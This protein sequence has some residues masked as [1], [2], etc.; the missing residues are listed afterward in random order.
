MKPLQSRSADSHVREVTHAGECAPVRPAGSSVQTDQF[1]QRDAW[2]HIEGP[3]HANLRTWLSA[4]R[5]LCLAALALA[6]GARAQAQSQPLASVRYATNFSSVTYFEPPHE[7]QVKMRLSGA[8]A[9]PLPNA[10]YDL[11]KMKVEQFNTEGK[12]AA[13]VKA[14]QCTYA[15]LDHVASSPGHL[16]IM[17]G[18]GKLQTEGD[19][20]LLKESEQSLVISNHVRSVI[21]TGIT[22]LFSL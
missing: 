14:P 17:S 5:M 6:V 21:S 11:K 7:Q 13:V 3:A 20:F 2:Q 12:L 1:R 16:E 9:A 15:L 10:L 18:N 4:L 8:E 19:G 22:N